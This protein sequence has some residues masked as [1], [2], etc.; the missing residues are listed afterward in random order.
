M[1]SIKQIRYALAVEE[2]GHFRAAA[3]AC[4]ISQPALSGAITELEKA[5]GFQIFERDSKKVLVTPLGDKMLR[6]ARDIYV[7]VSDL[8]SLGTQTTDPL[9][10]PMTI[11]MI[12]TIAPYLLPLVLPR[13]RTH[14]PNLKLTVD[15][16]QS[17][18][19]VRGVING[20]LDAAV[21]ALP[22]DLGGLLQFSFWDENFYF[23]AHAQEQIIDSPV[24]GAGDIDP[25]RLFLLREGH[26]LKDHALAICGLVEEQSINTRGSSLAT[27]IQ[28]VAGKLGTTLIPEIALASLLEQH[29]DL[30]FARLDESGPHRQLAFIIRPNFPRLGE[31]ELL[32]T[33]FKDALTDYRKKVLTAS[34]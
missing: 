22:Y 10:D 30:A 11:G 19:L 18:C 29:P 7:A 3:D 13:I 4:H 16:D 23:I 6:Q 12:P 33:L 8:E 25:S 14:Y 1:I 27:I 32:I 5:L 26:C 28:L 34:R 2:H 17:H 20:D 9:R 15:E 24:I 21:L 31:I